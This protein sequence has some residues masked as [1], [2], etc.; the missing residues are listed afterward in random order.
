MTTT[1]WTELSETGSALPA[2]GG[3]ERKSRALGDGG[4]RGE[5][6]GTVILDSSGK[7][8]KKIKGPDSAEKKGERV[9][10]DS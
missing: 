10:G 6:P 3:E 5:H 2:K 7:G 1:T 4:G 8:K 9:A